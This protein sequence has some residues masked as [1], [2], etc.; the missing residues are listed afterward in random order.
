MKTLRLLACVLGLVSLP[1]LMQAQPHP[2]KPIRIIAPFAAGTGPD[3]NARE[4]A[5]ELTKHLGQSVFVENRPGATG[6]IGT[7]VAA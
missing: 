6:I 1:V 2:N 4:L 5:A 3:A 7:E